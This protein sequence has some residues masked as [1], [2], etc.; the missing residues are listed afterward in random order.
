MDNL[1]KEIQLQNI[2]PFLGIYDAFSAAW[3]K[4]Q[5]AVAFVAYTGNKL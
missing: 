4:S 3:E 1:K 2:V 5:E